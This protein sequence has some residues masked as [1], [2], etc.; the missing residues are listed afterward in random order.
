MIKSNLPNTDSIEALAAFWDTHD[1]TAFQDELEEVQE[2]LFE[3]Q[4]LVRVPLDASN[5][6]A[7]Q[8]IARTKGVT[9]EEL[10]RSWVLQQLAQ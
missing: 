4:K 3:R 6:E 5:I 1:L 7:V 8:K 10:I 2:P 9:P